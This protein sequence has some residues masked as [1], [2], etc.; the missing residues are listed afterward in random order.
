MMVTHLAAAAAM[1]GR[2]HD[3]MCVAGV[4]NTSGQ[5]QVYSHSALAIAARGTIGRI[6]GAG[7]SRLWKS[8]GKRLPVRRLEAATRGAF[9]RSVMWL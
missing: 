4:R 1:I 9:A 7:Q 3:H 5:T 2:A 6:C 8:R